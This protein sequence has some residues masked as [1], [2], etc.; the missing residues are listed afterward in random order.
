M[1]VIEVGAVV[2]G[3]AGAAATGVAF[4]LIATIGLPI[5]RGGSFEGSSRAVPRYGRVFEVEVGA[6][7]ESDA[8]FGLPATD[9][10]SF[11]MVLF[12][13][14]LKLPSALRFWPEIPFPV[15]FVVIPSF[16]LIR[17]R[18]LREV[19]EGAGFAGSAPAIWPKMLSRN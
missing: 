7:E 2:A 1:G 12:G 3:A 16:W 15:S 6:V 18:E 14:S 19:L 17:G 9:P 8:A 10:I 11:R 5:G 4:G 13:I